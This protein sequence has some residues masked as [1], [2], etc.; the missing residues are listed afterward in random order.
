MEPVRGITYVRTVVYTDPEGNLNS[1][2]LLVVFVK[3]SDTGFTYYFKVVGG[4]IP[5][6][7]GTRW[8]M[9]DFIQSRV[10]GWPVDIGYGPEQDLII[11]MTKDEHTTGD[12][13]LGESSP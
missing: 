9:G 4:D 5:N 2:E 3:E 1:Y 6:K 8:K 13:K 7:R 11:Y 12:K 10:S